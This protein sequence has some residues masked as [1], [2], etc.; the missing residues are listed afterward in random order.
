MSGAAGGWWRRKTTPAKVETYTRWS[1]HFFAVIEVAVLGL[2]VFSQAGPGVAGWLMAM[3]VVHALLCAVTASR[4]LDWTRGRRG[5]PVRLLWALAAATY[6]FA[7]V[8]LVLREHGSGPDMNAVGGSVFTGVLAFGAGTTALGVHHRKRVLSL[9]AGFACGAGAVSFPLGYRGV[10]ALLTAFVVFLGGAFLAFTSIFSVWLLNA[11]YELDEARET[12]A[13]LAVAEE[14][15]RF[16]RDLHDVLGRNLAVIALKS[17][18]AVQLARRERPAAVDQMIEVQRIAQESQREVRDVV[19]GYR[20]ADLG[21]ELAGARG[22]LTAAGVDCEVT[23]D[24]AGL[25]AEVQSALGWVVR[26]A[27]TNV[28]RH[29]DAGRCTV[30]LRVREGHVVLTV[31]NDGVVARGTGGGGGS[32]LAGLRER[33]AEV[34]GTLEAGPVGTDGFRVVASVPLSGRTTADTSVSGVTS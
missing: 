31:E 12:R 30:G 27:T 17:E 9:V 24:A 3:V 10:A 2:P 7:V 29:G 28:L 32:G 22:V 25:P 19:R 23:G 1:F 21:T 14:R 4:A 11:V 18:L 33:L 20:E 34:D 8:A 26:E 5:Q 13:R 6:V 16:G 15:L